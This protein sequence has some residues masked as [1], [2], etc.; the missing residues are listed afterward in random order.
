MKW[1]LHAI[2]EDTEN[3][4][5][6]SR[7]AVKSISHDKSFLSSLPRYNYHV[8]RFC[9]RR[10]ESR[11]M[12]YAQSR[13]VVV[14]IGVFFVLHLLMAASPVG[15]TTYS[16]DEVIIATGNITDYIWSPDGTEIA[17]V[18]CPQSQPWGELWVCNWN[19]HEATNLHLLY[20]QIE[21]GG[22]EDW[23]GDWIL[24]RIRNQTDLPSEYYGRGE[25]W[26]LRDDGTNLTQIT[27]TY[28]DGIRTQWWNTHYDNIGTAG[29]G[30]F[31]PGTELVYFSAHDGNG[32]WRAFTCFANGTD[33]SKLISG[34]T[35][36]FTIGISP[37]GNK[38]LWGTAS[39]YDEPTTLMVSNINGSEVMIVKTFSYVATPLVLTDGDTVLYNA[40]DGAIGAIQMNGTSDRV[41][42]NDTYAN[43]WVNNNPIDEQ[44]FLMR[45]NRG[46][47]G[48]YHIFSADVNGSGIVQL[49]EGQHNDDSAILSPDGSD[50]LYR[51][52]PA[53]FGATS[54]E[55][56]IA[57]AT[58][59]APD[60]RIDIIFIVAIV[61]L[62]AGALYL[63][64]TTSKQVSDGETIDY[65]LED[66]VKSDEWNT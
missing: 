15:A 49:T 1:R 31:I 65:G 50:L 51:R 25:L 24:L 40:P 9:E 56:T 21:A 3:L 52:L 12:K 48:Y 17:Y 33:G 8:V 58:L 7:E 32:W 63:R 28:S 23:Q 60:L 2:S 4:A 27:F 16:E 53:Y 55:L 57:G 41:V 35:F 36:S 26:K 14:A 13:I 6:F 46:S 29:W 44:S 22:L 34:S 47:D 66:E 59:P 37:T 11:K 61:A 64:H 10:A 38:L 45:S 62:I 5:G 43:S 42:L 18:Q 30:R 39:Y 54:Y 20:S 19:G